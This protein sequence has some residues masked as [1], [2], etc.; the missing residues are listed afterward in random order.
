MLLSNVNELVC[1][2]CCCS[3]CSLVFCVFVRIEVSFVSA[4][5]YNVGSKI[6]LTLQLVHPSILFS[7]ILNWKYGEVLDVYE[8]FCSWWINKYH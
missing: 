4:C 7:L 8:I 2:C 3:S 5:S 1:D 6:S